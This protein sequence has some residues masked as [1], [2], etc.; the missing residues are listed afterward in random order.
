MSVARENG[1]KVIQTRWIDVNKGDNENPNYR[2]RL[3]AKEFNTGAIDGLFAATPPLEALRLLISQAATVAP[4]GSGERR[5]IMINDVARAFFEAPATRAVC[6]RLPPE[7]AQAEDMVGV[8]QLSLYGTR[9]AAANFQNEVRRFMLGLGFSQSGYSPSIF[10]HARK[11]LRTLVH[12][13]DFV[14][15]GSPSAALWLSL[16]HI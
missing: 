10:H 7:A 2:S 12:G 8:L 3:V 16:I 15:C 9:D 13:D 14:T 5:V 6:V 11:G 1:W 4:T